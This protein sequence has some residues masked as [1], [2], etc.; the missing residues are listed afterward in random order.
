[1]LTMAENSSGSI[2]ISI[3]WAL[4]LDSEP[5]A[6][7]DSVDA[8]VAVE[9]AWVVAPF[10]P[11]EPEVEAVVPVESEFEP[12]ATKAG[13]VLIKANRAINR[14]RRPGPNRFGR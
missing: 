6:P 10:A 1:M 8:F 4:L 2:A 9:D 14:V 12:H 7:S 13:V 3:E 5:T 11:D